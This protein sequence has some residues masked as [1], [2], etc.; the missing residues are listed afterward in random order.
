MPIL[1]AVR[2]QDFRCFPALDCALGDG[3]TVFIGDN[4]QGKTSV[5]EAAC[6][7]LRLHSPRTN[8][9]AELARFDH[10]GFGV[11]GD[12]RF[13]DGD[14]RRLTYHWREGRRALAVD[15]MAVA[16]PA[17]Y[18]EHS[19]VLVWMGHDDLSLLR[20]PGE[21]RRRYLDFLGAQTFPDYRAAWLA[22]DKALRSRNRLLKDDVVR[23]AELE[24]YTRPLVEHGALL[25]RWRSELVRDLDPQA[26]AAHRAVS[27]APDETL[28][29]A[30]HRGAGEDFA[31][32]LAARA[33]EERRRRVTV[34]G[35][36]RDDV[37]VTLNTRLAAAFGSEGQV[38]TAALA[39]KLA[40]ARLLQTRHGRPPLFLID[41]IFGELDPLRR[42]ALFRALPAGA[43]H[44]VTTTRLDWLTEDF[45]LD[46]LYHVRGGTLEPMASHQAIRRSSA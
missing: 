19:A 31:T 6:V 4:A 43:Q 29:L 9:P 36:H 42:N 1:T 33:E 5:L 25:T 45:P 34:A 21:G 8:N 16:R 28:A 35:P 38:R 3:A 15:G 7:L 41:D 10:P 14:T 44:L 40:Q 20:G 46:R 37:L 23:S 13:E 17:A 11:S 2:A 12:L 30:Y 26:A 22:Y 24:A 27:E 32:T 39:L 18:L